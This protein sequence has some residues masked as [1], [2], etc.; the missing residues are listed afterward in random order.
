MSQLRLQERNLAAGTDPFFWPSG[1]AILVRPAKSC[2][3][4]R[5]MLLHFRHSLHPWSLGKFCVAKPNKQGALLIGRMPEWRGRMDAQ[6]RPF[7]YFS[8]GTQRKVTRRRH[9]GWHKN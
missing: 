9:G 4:D 3:R 2:R 5:K 7:G 6:E 1:G 8:L